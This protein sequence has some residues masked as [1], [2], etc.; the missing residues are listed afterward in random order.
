MEDQKI[1]D[2]QDDIGL[3]LI[4]TIQSSEFANV[5]QDLGEVGLDAILK[6]GIFRELPVISTIVGVTKTV[7][8]IRD[9]LLLRKIYS[10]LQEL[11]GIS[12]TE[13]ERFATDMENDPKYQRQVGE[14]LIMLLDRLDD[15]GKPTLVARVFKA[16]L[17]G[18]INYHQFLH[19]TAV[20]D[21]ILVK[22]LQNLLETISSGKGS[23]EV[24]AEHL[25]QFGLSKIEFDDSSFV[26]TGSVVS[27]LK[28]N[29]RA[30]FFPSQSPVQFRLTKSAYLLAH[31]LPYKTCYFWQAKKE[32]GLKV[33][34]MFQC[35]L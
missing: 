6:D 23:P 4:E 18:G 8:A 34:R 25:Y 12:E 17:K 35:V 20:I 22:D 27:E 11:H 5:A 16:Y 1:L 29:R 28:T 2:S 19:F 31:S 3:S 32:D 13:K 7:L 26:K 33:H 14:N 30:I 21:K 9:K 15:L 24:F 10:F